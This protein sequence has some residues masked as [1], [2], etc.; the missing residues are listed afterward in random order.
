[1]GST[2]NP[3]HDKDSSSNETEVKDMRNVGR[4]I[5][6]KWDYAKVVCPRRGNTIHLT[7]NAGRARGT[8]EEP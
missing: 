7:L 3:A 6:R 8:A 1:M 5:Q 4:K 2:M